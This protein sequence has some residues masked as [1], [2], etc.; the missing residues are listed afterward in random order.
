MRPLLAVHEKLDKAEV[1]K[2][3]R[4][5]SAACLAELC[6]LVAVLRCDV[7][8]RLWVVG[9]AEV[10]QIARAALHVAGHER[11]RCQLVLLDVALQ[12]PA[13]LLRRQRRRSVQQHLDELRFLAGL[14]V[15]RPC[16]PQDAG[17]ILVTARVEFDLQVAHDDAL[18]T[19]DALPFCCR[20][21]VGKTPVGVQ[22]VARADHHRIR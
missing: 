8:E 9:S 14:V 2:P 1:D 6:Q 22:P 16:W 13:V 4:L 19:R 12:N 15:V 21:F 11:L 5:R 17:A 18:Q 3:K 20:D 10:R 7:S